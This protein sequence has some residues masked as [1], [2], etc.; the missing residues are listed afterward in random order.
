MQINDAPEQADLASGRAQQHLAKVTLDRQRELN[1]RG[2]AAQSALDQAQ[3]QY[4]AATASI[5][6]DDA[7]IA[8]Q[9]IRAPFDGMLGLRSVEVG[10]YVNTGAALVTLTDISFLYVDFTLPEQ[11]RPQL[12]VGQAVNV[13]VDAY[14]GRTFPAKIS[15]LDPQVATGHPHH[16]VAG[17][18]RQSGAS[19]DAR[20]VRQCAGRSA[21]ARRRADHPGNRARPYDLRRF[22]LSRAR[23]QTGS[24]RQAPVRRPTASPCSR[25]RVPVT[26]GQR[27]DG[28]VAVTGLKAGDRVVTAGQVKLFEGSLVTLSTETTLVNPSQIPLN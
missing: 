9:Q 8:Q 5:A 12:N 2:F 26:A 24:R 10:Q 22:G 18:R 3:S 1:K 28:R 15:V 21:A 7:V 23:S 19:F 17:D 20:H 11:A 27:L 13:S 16:Q 25:S 4:D 14:P 6:R